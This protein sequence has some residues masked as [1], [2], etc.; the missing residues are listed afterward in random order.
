MGIL[1][2]RD[3]GA[4]RI[5]YSSK[6]QSPIYTRQSHVLVTDAFASKYPE[7]TQQLVKAAVQAARWASD[8]KNREDAAHLG[9]R[10]H[11]LRAL[12]GGL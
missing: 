8:E 5:L 12:E 4:V 6:N 9:A 2:L 10:R 1:R 7:A 3:K 11:A